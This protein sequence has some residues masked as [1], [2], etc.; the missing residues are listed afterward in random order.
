[1]SNEIYK[2]E[3]K[4]CKQTKIKIKVGKYK[5]ASKFVDETGKLWLGKLCPSCNVE[6]SKANMQRLRSK[7][8]C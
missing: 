1:M 5:T 3:C 6:R 7:D 4:N 8:A 2:F